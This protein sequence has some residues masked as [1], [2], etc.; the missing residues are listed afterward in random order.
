MTQSEHMSSNNNLSRNEDEMHTLA[1]LRSSLTFYT[2]LLTRIEIGIKHTATRLPAS[3]G[4]QV[5]NPLMLKSTDL[6]LSA[7]IH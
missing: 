7:N 5:D 6:H 2:S 3:M 1:V 4:I